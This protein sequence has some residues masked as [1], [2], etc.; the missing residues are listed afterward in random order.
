MSTEQDNVARLRL[1]RLA[2]SIIRNAHGV[3]SF[4]AEHRGE[5]KIDNAGFNQIVASNFSLL[6]SNLATVGEIMKTRG[7]P[8]DDKTYAAILDQLNAQACTPERMAANIASA[9]EMVQKAGSAIL[10]SSTTRPV[11]VGWGAR[12]QDSVFR[13]P[14]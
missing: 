4:A 9:F 3:I 5:G 2:D 7:Y 1:K 11:A 14:V 10:P 8:G 12:A 13:F 6:T